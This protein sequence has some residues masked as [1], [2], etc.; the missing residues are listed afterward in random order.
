MTCG[1]DRVVDGFLVV[2][3]TNP[4]DGFRDE[5]DCASSDALVFFEGIMG[6]DG[7]LR[8]FALWSD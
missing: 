8:L 3:G 2:V 7:A 6:E 1:L 5:V 4:V